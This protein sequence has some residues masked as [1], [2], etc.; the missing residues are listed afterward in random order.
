[1]NK[2]NNNRLYPVAISTFSIC[3]Y[4]TYRAN[5]KRKKRCTQN[6]NNNY[7]KESG[8]KIER[9]KWKNRSAFTND[10]VRSERPVIITD[11]VK[12]WPA[13]KKWT[14]DFFL[15]YPNNGN[16]KLNNNNVKNDIDNKSPTITI[17]IGNEESSTTKSLKKKITLRTYM[18]S[19]MHKTKHGLE[20]NRKNNLPYLKQLDV[21]QILPLL[22]KDININPFS[23]WHSTFKTTFL[24]IGGYG[25]MTGMHNDDEN[26]VLCQIYGNKTV[27]LYP[28]SAREM[29]YVNGI[30]DSGTECCDI[31]VV[32]SYEDNVNKYPKFHEAKPFEIVCKLSPGDMLYI[33]KFWYH[34]VVSDKN[35]VSISVN[36]FVSTPYE[37]VKYGLKRNFLDFLHVYL[38]Y[39]K[40]ECVCCGN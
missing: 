15:N 36:H 2:G 27:Y 4:L 29:L 25:S 39:K 21:F 40:G 11:F 12:V 17:S 34:Q 35:N 23:K 31:D 8:N 18:Q 16:S 7:K 1:M 10:Y 6:D 26:N 33:P 28:P 38:N 5:K 14:P 9:T 20:G 3:M 13:F 30:Y 22:K 19:I 37:F 32:S 24:W